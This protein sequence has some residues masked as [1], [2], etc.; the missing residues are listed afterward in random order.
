M[1]NACKSLTSLD[2]SN[3]DTS[4]VTDMNWM[5]NNCS[6]L[7]SLD[8]SNFDTS[9]VTNM[10]EMFTGCS[11]LITLDLS[12]WDTS[13]AH[14]DMSRMFDSCS[15]L[16]TIKVG[17]KFICGYTLQQL[18]LFGTWQDET[19]KQYGDNDEFPSNVAHTYTKVS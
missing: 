13:K 9:N 8:V 4:K 5:F 7:T 3:F 14:N 19:G 15:N 16:T 12:N 18:S 1:F 10:S 6:N 17:D 11:K 2:I